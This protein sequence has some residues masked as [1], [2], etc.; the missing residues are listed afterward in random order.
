MTTNPSF[1]TGTPS[2]LLSGRLPHRSGPQGHSL[3]SQQYCII[4]RRMSNQLSDREARGGSKHGRLAAMGK[5]GKEGRR[6]SQM[7]TREHGRTG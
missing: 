5:G 3:G 1:A 6:A 7:N 2:R 4:L